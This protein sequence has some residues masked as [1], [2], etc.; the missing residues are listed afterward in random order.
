MLSASLLP[1]ELIL[2][3][4]ALGWDF[5]GPKGI[6]AG[7]TLRTITVP[8]P[9][10]S[11]EVLALIFPVTT[12]KILSPRLGGAVLPPG[13][14]SSLSEHFPEKSE[15]VRYVQSPSHSPLL[16]GPW[17]PL[18][19]LVPCRSCCFSSS[20]QNLL[21]PSARAPAPAAPARASQGRFWGG[22]AP[23]FSASCLMGKTFPEGSATA[24]AAAQSPII[25]SEPPNQQI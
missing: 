24:Q 19:H 22:F 18:R 7:G 23:C 1:E 5:T 15:V 3:R 10:K 17:V 4:L 6:Q 20:T 13:A 21:V 2:E 25:C 11:G 9:K 8:A 12:Q 16:E 14:P